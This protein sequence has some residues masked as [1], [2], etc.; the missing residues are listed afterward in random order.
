[1]RWPR[2]FVF[3]CSVLCLLPLCAQKAAPDEEQADL[4]E[5][6]GEAGNSTIDLI[7][8]I[9]AHLAKYPHSP[10]KHELE[11]ALVKG[12]IEIKD[13]RRIA[14]YGERVLVYDP[15]NLQILD[16]VARVLI[17]TGDQAGVER[18]LH[19]A[20]HFE[21]LVETMAEAKPTEGQGA[22]HRKD[23]LDHGL[24]RALMLESQASV[25]LG[26]LED[27][28]QFAQR[29]FDIFPSE[30][31]ARQLAATFA[32][33]GKSSEAIRHY[34]DAFSIPDPRAEDTDRAEDRRKMGELYKSAHGSE[35]GLGDLVLQAYDRTCALLAARRLALSKSDP[36]AQ[37]T[38]PMDFTLTDLK[39][40]K[41]RLSTLRGKVLVLDF[42]ATWCGPC[43]AQHPLYEQ[44]KQRF[45]NGDVVFLSIDSDDEHSLVQPF[46]N[47]NHWAQDNIY[48]EDGLS[49]ALKVSNIPTTIVFDKQGKIASRMNGYLPYRFVDM[50]TARI[51]DALEPPHP[52]Q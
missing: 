13:D 52:P 40:G 27:G 20:Q 42:W 37:V 30:E 9:E 8:A 10:R 36:N 46:V 41:L 31:S 50:L 26:R 34:A 43:R 4:R 15:D 29:G 16:N 28:I 11:R 23:E 2:S 1:M 18:A 49:R 48:F 25:K 7:R 19:Y 6:L 17:A 33:A 5:T 44:V 21:Q 39:G 51:R 3:L 22:A 24:G 35:A 45:N 32:A 14:L 47:Q 12:S 38:D